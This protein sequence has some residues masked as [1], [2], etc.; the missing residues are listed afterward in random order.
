MSEFIVSYEARLKKLIVKTKDRLVLRKRYMI[1]M[2]SK[3][4][5]DMMSK[6]IINHKI[7]LQEKKEG[8]YNK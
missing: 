5:S 8:K 1:E 3:N 2:F 4:N 6:L 7:Y